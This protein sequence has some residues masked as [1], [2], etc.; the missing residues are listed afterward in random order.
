MNI[1]F[2]TQDEPF[3][4]KSFFRRFLSQ[5]L[6]KDMIK[7]VLI[8]KTF[9]QGSFSGVLKKALDFYGKFGFFYMGLQYAGIKASDL[10]SRLLNIQFNHS[11]EQIVEKHGIPLLKFESV[12]GVDFLEF[13][14]K[15]DISLI[16]SVAASE[17]FKKSVLN[18]PAMGC[19]NVHSAPLPKYRGMMPNF[20]TLYNKEEYAWIT[21]H[22]MVE[23]LDEG[24]IILQESFNVFPRESYNSLAKRSKEYAAEL[25]IKVLKM[26]EDGTVR[27]LPNDSSKATYYTFPTKEEVHEF[28]KRGGRII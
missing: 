16:I 1:M 13:I 9:N 15:E 23:K 2:V 3:Y 26:F 14:R 17:I 27:Y 20:W 5:Y 7:G 24:P 28:K 12:N 19:I 10:Q 11:I 18:A 4:I 21:V 8:Q 22:K 25:L 6:E